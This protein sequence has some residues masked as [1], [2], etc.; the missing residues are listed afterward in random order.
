MLFLV[1]FALL[2]LRLDRRCDHSGSQPGLRDGASILGFWWGVL[3][4]ILTDLRRGVT[5]QAP[6]RVIAET[7]RA[8]SLPAAPATIDLLAR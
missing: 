1:G 7:S 2:S 5:G 4:R 6:S 3:P 8:V